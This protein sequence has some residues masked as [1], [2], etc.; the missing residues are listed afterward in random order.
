MVWNPRTGRRWSHWAL[1]ESW[2]AGCKA[3]GLPPVPLYEGT[4]HSFATEA[5]AQGHSIDTLQ[6]YLGHKDR[7]STERYAKIQ[8]AALVEIVRR[9]KK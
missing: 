4:K 8:D 3:A 6:R 2:L 9:R 1:R 7:R 5:L